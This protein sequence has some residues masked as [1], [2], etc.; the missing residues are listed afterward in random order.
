MLKNIINWLVGRE[1]TVESIVSSYV[2][3]VEDLIAH[4]E[5]KTIEAEK[6]AQ[7]AFTADMKKL[8]AAAEVVKA[9]AL[10]AKLGDLFK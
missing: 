5:Q 8:E 9:E 4:A 3:T 1:R 7:A 2:K 10:A 6:H